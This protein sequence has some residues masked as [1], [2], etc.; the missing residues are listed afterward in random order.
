LKEGREVDESVRVGCMVYRFLMECLDLH[1]S[2]S[3]TT[4]LETR[5]AEPGNHEVWPRPTNGVRGVG[6]VA[7]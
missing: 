2:K 1:L 5:E 3:M 4:L 7:P 6:D